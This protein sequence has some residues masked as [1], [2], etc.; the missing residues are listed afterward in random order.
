MHVLE[1]PSEKALWLIFLKPDLEIQ[2]CCCTRTGGRIQRAS[3]SLES[4]FESHR[5]RS[6][7]AGDCTVRDNDM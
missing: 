2:Y 7:E 5:E 6:L 3:R 1:V 4:S